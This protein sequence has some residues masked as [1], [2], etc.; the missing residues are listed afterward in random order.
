[1]AGGRCF[2]KRGVDLSHCCSMCL[3]GQACTLD[4]I[5]VLIPR[6]TTMAIRKPLHVRELAEHVRRSSLALVGVEGAPG[7]M[8]VLDQQAEALAGM[9]QSGAKP[10]LLLVGP[11]GDFTAEELQALFDAGAKPV[12]LLW[13]C[14]ML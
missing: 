7:I 14:L 11:E 4:L 13:Q 6:S 5:L 10:G 9:D 3:L 8:E 2:T 12:G 1:M